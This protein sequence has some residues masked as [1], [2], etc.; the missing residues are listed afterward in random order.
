MAGWLEA[1]QTVVA[2]L[3]VPSKTLFTKGSWIDFPRRL[4]GRID[5]KANWHD[6]HLEIS[7]CLRFD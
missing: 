6:F 1:E 5:S 3:E 4:L 7:P 2:R